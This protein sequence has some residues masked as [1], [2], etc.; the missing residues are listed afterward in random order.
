M[1]SCGYSEIVGGNLDNPANVQCVTIGECSKDIKGHLRS[2]K[3]SNASLDSEAKLL[4][5]RAGN[6]TVE[7]FGYLLL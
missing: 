1:A 5:A 4:L 6:C 3:V 2:Y 7:K